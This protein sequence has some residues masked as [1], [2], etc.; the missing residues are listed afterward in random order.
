M[1][2]SSGTHTCIILGTCAWGR[3]RHPSAGGGSVSRRHPFPLA[4]LHSTCQEMRSNPLWGD[5]SKYIAALLSMAIKRFFVCVIWR[6]KLLKSGVIRYRCGILW[7]WVVW[8][9]N[10]NSVSLLWKKIGCVFCLN[11]IFVY[12]L[13]LYSKFELLYGIWSNLNTQS[14]YIKACWLCTEVFWKIR[15]FSIY[16]CIAK[17][18]F[19]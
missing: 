17:N 19:M 2:E 5:I 12:S 7:Y 9:R 3:L 4:N 15:K 11:D 18:K 1:C 10:L 13:L 8:E 14:Y 16:R 6:K